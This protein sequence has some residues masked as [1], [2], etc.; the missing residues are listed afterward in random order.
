MRIGHW[1]LSKQA[2]DSGILDFPA[3]V[4]TAEARVFFDERGGAIPGFEVVDGTAVIPIVGVLTKEPDFFF[5]MFGGGSSSYREIAEAVRAADGDPEVELT[6]LVISSP[7]GEIAGLLDTFNAIADSK[8]RVVAE[9]EDMAASAAFALATAADEI[10]VNNAMAMVG[11]VGVAITQHTSEGDVRLHSTDAPKKNPDAATQEGRD[12]IVAELD[13]LHEEFVAMIARGRGVEVSAVNTDFGRGALVIAGDALTAKMIDRIGS[14]TSGESVSAAQTGANAMTLEEFLAAHP[15]QRAA[16]VA[17][18]HALGVTDE[19]DR[20]SAHLEAATACG[21]PEL[22][23]KFI[24][25]GSLITS[26]VAH[27]AY[28]AASIKTAT[29]AARDDDD[30][31]AAGADGAGA[32]AA[33]AAAAADGSPSAALDHDAFVGAVFD[34]MH[35]YDRPK[36]GAQGAH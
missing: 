15:E 24:A 34:E 36:A 1:F 21:K 8:T 33:D 29:G 27:G 5:S 20:V 30:G 10:T 23:V 9:V 32:G 28:L 14:A 35:K 12:V 22:A 3:E 6:K 13:A 11:S 4:D 31:A 7:G 16:V 19:R 26:Q 25:D 18:G 17:M 2:F